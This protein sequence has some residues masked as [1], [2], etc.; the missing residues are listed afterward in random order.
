MNEYSS[1]DII[2]D[3]RLFSIWWDELGHYDNVNYFEFRNEIL[4]SVMRKSI[5]DTIVEMEMI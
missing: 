5:Y 3:I 1:I 4:G 2:L